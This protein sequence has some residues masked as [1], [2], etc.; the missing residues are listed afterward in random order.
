MSFKNTAIGGGLG[1]TIMSYV[2]AV[3]LSTRRGC[4]LSATGPDVEAT[5]GQNVVAFHDLS[6][7]SRRPVQGTAANQPILVNSVAVSGWSATSYLSKTSAGGGDDFDPGTRKFGIAAWVKQYGLTGSQAIFGK[8]NPT[9]NQRSFLLFANA[10]TSYIMRVYPNGVTAV[11]ATS[12]IVPA[13]GQ[14]RFLVGN[15]DTSANTVSISVNGETLVTTTDGAITTALSS[16]EPFFLGYGSGLTAVNGS[17]GQTIYR[18]GSTFS[19]AEVTQLYNSGAGLPYARWDAG[20]K[21]N[22]VSCWQHENA[23]GYDVHSTNHLTENGT[24]LTGGQGPFAIL[25]RNYLFFDGVNDCL[26]YNGQYLDSFLTTANAS[27]FVR[28]IVMASTANARMLSVKKHNLSD[29]TN[30]S[31]TIIYFATGPSMRSYR[32]SVATVYS[33]PTPQAVATFG[34][35]FSASAWSAYRD[36]TV[37]AGTP[38]ANAFDANSILIGAGASGANLTPTNYMRCLVSDVVIYPDTK[39]TGQA[40]NVIMKLNGAQVQ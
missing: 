34:A 37:T 5:V 15:I 38:N 31:S 14:W 21:T 22:L 1:P 3:F 8:F 6:G 27:V 25:D 4:A 10:A 17:I 13:T 30:S 35:V 2:P 28:G 12:S 29:A 39:A 33:P 40:E 32:N 16:G 11:N 9:G 18:L 23:F 24:G 20:L 7:N 36:T 19:Q 26:V